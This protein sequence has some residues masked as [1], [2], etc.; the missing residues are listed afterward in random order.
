MN[1]TRTVIDWH[2]VDQLGIGAQVV[3]LSAA[4]WTLAAVLT[5]AY[6]SGVLFWVGVLVA[7]GAFIWTVTVY[8]APTQL[9]E[10]PRDR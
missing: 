8:L 9:R 7:I 6:W 2:D 1:D 10:S 4:I 3:V 5:L